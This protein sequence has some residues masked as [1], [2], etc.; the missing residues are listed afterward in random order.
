MVSTIQSTVGKVSPF[1]HMLLLGFACFCWVTS[2]LL[3]VYIAVPSIIISLLIL[4]VT[5][6]YHKTKVHRC[7]LVF[8]LYLAIAPFLLA[9]LAFML[10]NLISFTT[11]YSI[12]FDIQ[13]PRGVVTIVNDVSIEDSESPVAS[14]KAFYSGRSSINAESSIVLIGKNKAVLTLLSP[15]GIDTIS[16]LKHVPNMVKLF[17]MDVVSEAGVSKYILSR[18]PQMVGFIKSIESTEYKVLEQNSFH[19]AFGPGYSF[20]QAWVSFEKVE[21]T[22]VL[23]ET[24]PWWDYSRMIPK[25]GSFHH[26]LLRLNPDNFK[27]HKDTSASFF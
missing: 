23:S 24:V 6:R 10:S 8:V 15:K 25:V 5:A 22:N 9:G 7:G 4:G 2:G 3:F 21:H 16:Y 13:T 14:L 27:V 20:L 11:E 17:K 26:G 1:L 12:G 19:E 18:P